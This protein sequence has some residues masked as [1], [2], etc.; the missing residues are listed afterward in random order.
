[1][2][3]SFWLRCSGALLVGVALTLSAFSAWSIPTQRTTLQRDRSIPTQRTTAQ[4]RRP[5][6]TQRTTLQRDRSIP[7]QRTTAQ[8][9]RSIPV[10]RTTAQRGR[11][12]T[13]QRTTLQKRRPIFTPRTTTQR[14]RSITAQRTTT[15]RG[16][17]ITAQ[18]TT[19]QRG[20][21]ITAQRTTLQKR[22]PISTLTTTAQKRR[23]ISTL[24][25]TALK[26]K[27][28]NKILDMQETQ[29]RWIEVD[30]SNQKLIAWEGTS[31]VR[32]VLVST[33]KQSTPTRVGTF[34]VQTKYLSTRMKG[35]GYDVT[36]VPHT[37][38]YSGGYAIHGAYWHKRF[39]T[40]VSHGCINVA[41]DHAEWL[42]K[43]SNV[44]TPVIVHE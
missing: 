20:R 36:N 40:P 41:L 18:R 28:A 4:K 14:G 25:T 38:Y 33:G 23:P 24:T 19:T 32:A 44:G 21:S 26:D 12:I 16:R 31:P 6:P 9:G 2:I 27:I 29:Q 30:L 8:R 15:Q 39:G 7:T 1:M 42:F 13:A 11:P 37:M 22:R 35:P 43:W 5:T 10:Q 17:S 34:A 3:S